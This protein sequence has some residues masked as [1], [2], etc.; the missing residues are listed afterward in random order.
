MKIADQNQWRDLRNTV[1]T[2]LNN[3]G[4]PIKMG[5]TAQLLALSMGFHS[6]AALLTQ[7]PVHCDE[8]LA[9]TELLKLLPEMA[10]QPAPGKL[11]LTHKWVVAL[12]SRSA[13]PGG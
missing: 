9:A 3:A 10:E 4:I 1:K 6:E 2:N 7:F 5:K 8:E 13:T 12:L 11:S